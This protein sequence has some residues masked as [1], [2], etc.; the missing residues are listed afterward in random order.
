MNL[1]NDTISLITVLYKHDIDILK[2]MI[3]S[4]VT[5]LQFC[6]FQYEFL[7]YDTDEYHKDFFNKYRN[8]D[9]LFYYSG[10]NL[11]YCGGNNYLIDKSSGKYIII[12]NP[13]IEIRESL[14]FDWLIGTNKLYNNNCIVGKLVGTNEWY[15]YPASFPTDKMYDPENLPFYYDQH[16]L[17]KEGNWKKLP[18]IDGSL[19]SFTKNLF[20]EIGGFDED[21]FPGYF[22]ENAFCY[23]ACLNGYELANGYIK[24]LYLHHSH[25]TPQQIVKN[26]AITKSARQH[27]YKKYALPNWTHFINFLDSY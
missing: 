11:G 4:V 6:P 26:K 19:M 24:N 8:T 12:I 2:T 25:K 9:N 23:K 17:D 3:K 21:F 16:T 20:N 14:C 5:T 22:G 15:T 13:D 10:P 18:Y 27:F 7:F 1:N